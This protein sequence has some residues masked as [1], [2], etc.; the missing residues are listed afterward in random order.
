MPTVRELADELNM[1]IHELWAFAPDLPWQEG[2]GYVIPEDE[3]ASIR[4]AMQQA[5]KIARELGDQSP[6]AEA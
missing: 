4:E 6:L 1:T 5:D 2:S 3:A